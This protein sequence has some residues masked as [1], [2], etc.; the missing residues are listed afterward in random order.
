MTT[1]V[2]ESANTTKLE[3]ED[4][5]RLHTWLNTYSNAIPLVCRSPEFVFHIPDFRFPLRL[6]RTP[7][8]HDRTGA[9]C[10]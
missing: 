9:N 7:L 10:A 5:S 3:S 6:S 4:A 8:Q 1:F 2:S